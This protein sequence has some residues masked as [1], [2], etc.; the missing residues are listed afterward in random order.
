MVNRII[1]NCVSFM[2]KNNAIP[3]TQ[4]QREIYSYGLELQIYYFI[5]AVLITGIGLLFGHAMEMAFFLFLFGTIQSNG[6]GYHADTH[7]KC[8]AIM[9]FG[10]LLFMALL[11]F[12]QKHL[13][14]QPF[15]VLFGLIAVLCL[16]P[17]AHNNHPL[18]PQMSKRMGKKAKIL[19][20]IISLSWF[21]F[22]FFGIFLFTHSLVSLTMF[23]SGISMICA[24]VKNNKQKKQSL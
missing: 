12:Y 23:F 3:D 15:C 21:L 9:V 10:A 16:A 19:T 8:L 14:L 2:V 22:Y 7:G 18:S 24:W 17:V 13:L 4:E 11:P 6:G 1:D 5:H 20:C